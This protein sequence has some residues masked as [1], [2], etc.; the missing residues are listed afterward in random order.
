MVILEDDFGVRVK[1]YPEKMWT[2]EIIDRHDVFELIVTYPDRCTRLRYRSKEEA[3][4]EMLSL[5][6][7]MIINERSDK[8]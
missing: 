6:R 4:T 3:R 5:T 1:A 7:P 2:A 8:W